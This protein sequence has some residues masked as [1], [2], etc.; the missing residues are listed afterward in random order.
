[1]EPGQIADDRPLEFSSVPPNFR[2]GAK[3]TRHQR[4]RRGAVLRLMKGVTGKVLDYGCGYG[5]LAHAISATN[6]IVG[7]DVEAERVTFATH[8]YSPIPFVQCGANGA[9]FEDQS[10]DVVLSVVVIHFVPDPAGYLAEVSRLLKPGGTLVIICRN[11]TVFR[12]GVRRLFGMGQ[13]KSRLWVPTKAEMTTAITKAG[14]QIMGSTFFY[15]PLE[16]WK[17]LGDCVFG[18]IEQLCSFLCVPA[19]AN[20]YGYVSHKIDSGSNR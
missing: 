20:Y 2:K 17:N 4:R 9:P 11:Q 12:N 5:D 19:T 1:M 16:G 7:C 8:E 14:F 10:F 13:A 6:P 3:P 18:T 15:D